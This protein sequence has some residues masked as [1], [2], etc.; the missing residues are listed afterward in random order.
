MK[1]DLN[2]KLLN[3]IKDDEQSDESYNE[4]NSKNSEITKKIYYLRKRKNPTES[5]S[6]EYINNI[7]LNKKRK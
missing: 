7:Y 2:K 5:I 6:N 3:N 1:K 4:I